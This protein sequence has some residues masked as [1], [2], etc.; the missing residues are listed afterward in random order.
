MIQ[1]NANT[2]SFEQA[3]NVEFLQ[4]ICTHMNIALI[5]CRNKKHEHKDKTPRWTKFKCLVVS[6]NCFLYQTCI[7]FINFGSSLRN[8][9]KN[10]EGTLRQKIWLTLFRVNLITRILSSLAIMVITGQNGHKGPQGHQ[11][12]RGHHRSSWL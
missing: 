7:I 12:H 6:F 9:R 10:S 3:A 8:Y 4:I 1:N 5:S 2:K 11:S